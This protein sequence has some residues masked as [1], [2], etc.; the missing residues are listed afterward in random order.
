[1]GMMHLFLQREVTS[2]MKHI[3][4]HTVTSLRRTLE[5]QSL[6]AKMCRGM[7]IYK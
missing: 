6:F 2:E 7:F 4:A 1:M 5:K 3:V